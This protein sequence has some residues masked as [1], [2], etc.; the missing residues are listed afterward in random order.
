MTRRNYNSRAVRKALPSTT[1][2]EC[3]AADVPPRVAEMNDRR[4]AD[5]DLRG[6]LPSAVLTAKAIKEGAALI[7]QGALSKDAWLGYAFR[8]AR[9]L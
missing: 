6:P 1:T 2:A 9:E 7:Y 5:F 3:H 8:T 4:D